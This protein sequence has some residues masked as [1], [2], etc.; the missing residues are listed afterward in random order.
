MLNHLHLCSAFQ[1]DLHSNKSFTMF[2]SNT[3]QTS[4]GNV[5]VS[6]EDTFTGEGVGDGTTDHKVGVQPLS[7][8]KHHTAPHWDK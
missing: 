2:S 6:P 8:L 4:G 7:H 5:R 1:P 3:N